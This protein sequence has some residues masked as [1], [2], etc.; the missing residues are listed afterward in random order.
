MKRFRKAPFSSFPE[1]LGNVLNHLGHQDV[2]SFTGSASTALM[3][4][5]NKNILEKS[6]PFIAEQDSLNATVLGPDAVE[7]TPE[8]DILVK[9]VCTEMTAKAGQKCTAIRRILVSQEML[10]TV[11]DAIAA[12]LAEVKVGNPSLPETQMGALVSHP[13][14]EDVQS[15]LGQLSKETKSL[16]G[17]ELKSAGGGLDAGA[18]MKPQ[19]LCCENPDD[20][21]NVHSIEAFGPVSTLMPY[22]DIDHAGELLN[23]GGGSLVFSLISHDTDVA[24]RL[25][26]Q[27]ATWHGRVYINNRDSIKEST[28]HGSPL[29]HM[30]HGGP[31]RAGGGE[32]LGG[33]RGRQT[34]YG[35]D[36]G[37]RFSRHDLRRWRNVG[38]R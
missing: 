20:A 26:A 2:V 5:S 8:F 24:K 3:L 17:G 4:R 23:R 14:R 37:S 31:G 18:F 35:P 21:T 28:G 25:I 1:A 19:L 33:I 6:V 11:S 12:K 13:H 10:S 22:R 34:L 30:V 36:C 7:G 38:S 32:E 15:Q 16:Y 29:P 9:E 27:S